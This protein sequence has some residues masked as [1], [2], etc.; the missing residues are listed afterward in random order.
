[1]SIRRLTGPLKSQSGQMSIR[2]LTGALICQSGQ[3]S[4][5]QLTGTTKTSTWSNE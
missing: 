1:M 3:M 5:R 2:R 4:L